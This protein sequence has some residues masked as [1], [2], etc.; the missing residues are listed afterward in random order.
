MIYALTLFFVVSVTSQWVTSGRMAWAFARDVRLSACRR[1][2]SEL[3]YL[4]Y[5]LE[6]NTILGILL[7]Y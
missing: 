5:G 1:Y 6:W 4:S 7:R 2:L 3:T